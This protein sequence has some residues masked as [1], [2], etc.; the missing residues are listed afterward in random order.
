MQQICVFVNIIS[1]LKTGAVRLQQQQLLQLQRQHQVIH[2][3]DHHL[4][5]RS[6]M[7]RLE[8]DQVLVMHRCE[9]LVKI[10]IDEKNQLC[11]QPQQ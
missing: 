6:E 2:E 3:M 9:V 1:D 4:P 11:L 5:H 7:V 10:G 8:L